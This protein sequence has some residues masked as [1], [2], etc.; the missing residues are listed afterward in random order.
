MQRVFRRGQKVKTGRFLVILTSS[1]SPIRV[2]LIGW[3]TD[4]PPLY[5]RTGLYVTFTT[6]SGLVYAVIFTLVVHHHSTAE[7]WS[8]QMEQKAPCLPS[9]LLPLSLSLRF[10]P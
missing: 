8:A 4:P 5:S 9:S 3:I 7:H 6:R 1:L 2:V 10:Y